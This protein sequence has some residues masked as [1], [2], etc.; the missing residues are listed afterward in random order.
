MENDAPGDYSLR[1]GRV[2]APL[3]EQAAQVIRRAI[4]E[5]HFKPGQRLIERDLIEQT[6]VSRTTIREV[7]R[8]LA[9][10]GLVTTIPQKGVI[11]VSLTEAEVAHLYEARA[12][13]ESFVGR[14]FAQRATDEQVK[15]LR[16][17]F[18][19]L[20]KELKGAPEI[21]ERLDA[22]DRFYDLLLEGAGN[23]EIGALLGSLQD[24]VR[25]MRA[26]SLSQPGRVNKTL[27]EIQAIVEAIEARDPDAAAVACERHVMESA[28]T[29]KLRMRA[30]EESDQAGQKSTVPAR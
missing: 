5:F 8:Q 16:A 25:L 1:V 14:Q 29:A 6:G 11:V 10:E 15:Q 28:A 13:L 23:P 18:K 4:L 12:L 19:Q 3:R 20:S 26:R 9:A 30:M 7:L 27:K 17:G 24:R 22:K 2:T 21:K